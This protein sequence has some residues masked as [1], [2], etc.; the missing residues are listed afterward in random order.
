MK[1][2]AAVEGWMDL[3]LWTSAMESKVVRLTSTSAA[4]F[5]CPSALHGLG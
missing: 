1:M 3:S 5:R 4:Y 2:T